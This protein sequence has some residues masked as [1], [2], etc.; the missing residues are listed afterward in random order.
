MQLFFN[1][2]VGS[3]ASEYGL[4]SA[5]VALVMVGGLMTV[6]DSSHGMYEEL[7]HTMTGES[8]ESSSAHDSAVTVSLSMA[9]ATAEVA[10]EPEHTVKGSSLSDDEAME[11]VATIREA[12]HAGSI[13]K[14]AA[15][16][17][18]RE[19]RSAD[20][21]IEAFDIGALERSLEESALKTFDS[22][23]KRALESLESVEPGTVKSSR[24][25]G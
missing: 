11:K 12:L 8:A 22:S 15:V 13:S 5:L 1:D 14:E 4:L 17:A 9:R 10:E 19:L 21:S 7:V 6:G 25:P 24:R 2:D 23:S 18:E 20:V 3:T 16:E